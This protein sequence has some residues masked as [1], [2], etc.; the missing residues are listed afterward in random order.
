M[1]AGTAGTGRTVADV[2]ADPMDVFGIVVAATADVMRLAR[3][4]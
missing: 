2:S 3:R 1:R 4:A